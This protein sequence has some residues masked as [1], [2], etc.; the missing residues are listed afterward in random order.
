[1]HVDINFTNPMFSINKV[2]FYNNYVPEKCLFVDRACRYEVITNIMQSLKVFSQ[3]RL[4]QIFACGQSVLLRV[5]LYKLG[6]ES[7]KQ[8][9]LLCAI[10][11]NLKK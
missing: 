4:P 5:T 7:C 2:N 1:M 3:K 8:H 10:N 11:R 9:V 6:F